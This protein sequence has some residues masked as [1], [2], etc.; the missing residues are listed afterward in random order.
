MTETND[1]A[2]YVALA[3]AARQLSTTEMKILMLLKRHALDGALFDGSW[4]VT[5]DSI[6]RFD[7]DAAAAEA[8]QCRT[9]CS[10]AGC[11]CR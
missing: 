11:A 7:K 3:G 10:S 6:A 4:F 5:S 2:G 8:P 1:P 9:S